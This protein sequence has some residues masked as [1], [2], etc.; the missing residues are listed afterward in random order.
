MAS[1]HLSLRLEPKTLALLDIES[2]RDGQTRSQFA[3]TVLEEGLR[4]RQHPGVVF[5]S[6]PVGRR[7]GLADGPD[8]WEVAQVLRD[9][10]ER[11]GDV[12]RESVDLTGLTEQQIRI[13]LRY[14]TDYQDEID[15]W[16][17]LND[18]EAELAEAAWRR[19]QAF[20]QR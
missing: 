15:E 11:C 7:P 13:A 5:R 10:K 17:R 18:E 9:V 1:R 4:M 6:G 2:R 19:E 16:I 8:I 3:R 12:I 14:Y 20:L